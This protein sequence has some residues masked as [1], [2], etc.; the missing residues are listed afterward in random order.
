M[1]NRK[2]I[3]A[4]VA[5]VGLFFGIYSF[6]QTDDTEA[7]V[8]TLKG[9]AKQTIEVGSKY[10]EEGATAIDDDDT[11]LTDEIIIDGKVDENKVG[12]YKITYNV[13]DSAGNDAEEKVRTVDVVDTTSPVITLNGQANMIVRV[14]SNYV[15]AGVTVI[16]N[17]DKDI[18]DK[19][20]SVSNVNTNIVGVYT[21][22][23]DV[24]DSEGNVAQTVVRTV[25][26]V[27]TTAPIITLLGA[28]DLTIEVGSTYTDAGATALDNYDND[29]TNLIVVTG[30]VDPNKVGAYT[31]TYDVTDSN[32]NVAQSVVRTVNVVDTTAPIITLLGAEDLTIEVGS[33]YTDA[34]ATALDNYDNDITNLI[35]VTGAVD[36]TTVGTYTVH[37][38]VKDRAGNDADEIIRTVI[39][40]DT[41]VPVITLTGEEE[42][43][44]ELGDSYTDAGATA[45]DNYDGDLTDEINIVSTVNT[46]VT[47]TYTVTYN[48]TDSE[49]NVALPVTRT[50]NVVEAIPQGLIFFNKTDENE[51]SVGNAWETIEANNGAVYEDMIYA[52]SYD[53]FDNKTYYACYDRECVNGTKCY[54]IKYISDKY[55]TPYIL[56]S[57]SEVDL[58][59]PGSYQ[60][61]YFIHDK[62]GHT[63]YRYRWVD[64][65]DTT[66]P[67]ITYNGNNTR[68]IWEYH[69]ADYTGALYENNNPFV[70]TDNADD[71]QLVPYETKIRYDK[72]WDKTSGTYDGI[73]VSQVDLS[74]TGIYRVDFKYKDAAGNATYATKLIE[75]TDTIDPTGNV[76]FS[77]TS[78]TNE[79]V[80]VTLT[81]SEP[82]QD[83]LG[84][85]KNSAT[86]F[87]KIYSENTIGNVTVNFYDTEDRGGSVTFFIDNIDKT[88][89]EVYFN[90]E[91][92]TVA[93]THNV[94]V[95][96][97]DPSGI[98]HLRYGW[99]REDSGIQ[100]NQITN[101]LVNDSSNPNIVE[102]P[103]DPNGTY[104]LWVYFKDNAKNRR[105]LRVGPFEFDNEAPNLSISY[106]TLNQ[107]NDD[108]T[109]TITANEMVQSVQ[110]WI[111]SPDSLTLTKVYST[112]VTNDTV[113]VKDIAGNESN[114]VININN[115]DKCGPAIEFVTNGTTNYVKNASTVVNVTDLHSSLDK[116]KYIW[117]NSDSEPS[118]WSISTDFSSG[119][120][121]NTL[122]DATGLYYLWVYAE[123]ATS[124]VTINK[125]NAFKLDNTDPSKS[126]VNLNG[127]TE[128]EWTNQTINI[129]LESIDNISGIQKYQYQVD[130]DGEWIDMTSNTLTL[131]GNY[132]VK[133]KFRSI[134]NATNVSIETRNYTVKEDITEP[135]IELLGDNPLVVNRS[136]FTRFSD[137]DPGVNITDNYNSY[138]ELDITVTGI[139]EVNMRNVGKYN[140]VYTV[141]DLAGNTIT[142]TRTVKIIESVPPVILLNYPLYPILG[143]DVNKDTYVEYGASAYDMINGQGLNTTNLTNQ[144]VTTGNVDTTKLGTYYITYSVTDWS[145]NRSSVTR[146]IEVK[147]K[148]APVITL[149]TSE[150]ISVTYR[151]KKLFGGTKTIT[152][153][154]P[155]GIA[156]DNYDGDV[157]N[158]VQVRAYRNSLGKVKVEY[159]VTDAHNNNATETYNYNDID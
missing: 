83:I 122:S 153:V 50:I 33:T 132:D 51:V 146:T 137:V 87:T 21:V 90:I 114:D 130:D 95:Y 16:D 127:Y 140:I 125:S 89:A 159:S 47:G 27:D 40:E 136:L 85:T 79:D 133:V 154:V 109:V 105:H 54:E 52:K 129:T 10:V 44:L 26:V 46:S 18:V 23:Y 11:D 82:V 39:V 68:T 103:T 149:S 9:D 88:P 118:D 112:N 110:G 100:R 65:V 57:V 94:T 43:T 45:T 37:F 66:P 117:S 104:Y 148:S 96:A 81:T 12:T 75:V 28:E 143:L 53:E 150:T 73:N 67:T 158:S 139:N 115:I 1:L 93:K 78:L 76:A 107:T 42:V 59:T 25:N 32:G 113:V 61:K 123:D 36:T 121:I 48:V 142:A 72:D 2:L 124:N 128:G 64:V 155:K 35:V 31:I 98:A 106:S 92:G 156:V 69:E 97:T 116:I 19:V 119:D 102:Q 147:D 84:W 111:L 63:N 134:D 99:F 41:T 14:H 108:V 5:S 7:P 55:A 62:T 70:V 6:A 49:G 17:Y 144:I 4:F 101:N 34:G 71:G 80:M 60:V 24:T 58:G 86:E 20:S 91:S 13:S 56:T 74:K 145:G 141:T 77:T 131:D 22:T 138:D 30:A 151:T 8:I 157:S 29:I 152:I 120:V 126:T 135:T 3:V 15:D 38:N